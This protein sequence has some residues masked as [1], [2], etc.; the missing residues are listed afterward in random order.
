MAAHKELR[1][2]KKTGGKFVKPKMQFVQHDAWNPKK[3]GGEYDSSKEVTE[4]L[5]GKEVKGVWIQKGTKGVFDYEEF[6]ETALE[7]SEK[8]HDSKDAPFSEAGLARKKKAALEQFEQGSQAR[9]K[10]AVEHVGEELSMEA[11][12]AAVQGSGA[13][14]SSSAP[15]LATGPVESVQLSESSCSSGGSSSSEEG[16]AENIFGPKTKASQQA[17]GAAA[18]K[19]KQNLPSTVAKSSA[20]PS[21]PKQHDGAAATK[22]DRRSGAERHVKGPQRQ[23]TQDSGSSTFLADGRA[24]RALRNLLEKKTEL[25]SK[26]DAVKVDDA[27]PEPDAHSQAAFKQSC[28]DRV[29]TLKTLGRQA[30]DYVKRMDKSANKEFFEEGILALQEVETTALALQNLLSSVSTPGSVP[31]VIV[32]AYEDVTAQQVSLGTVRAST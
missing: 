16:A 15:A 12:V 24:Q 17:Q 3:H 1:L 14:A 28:A 4:E 25:K 32:K 31:D 7:E 19:P 8:L 11:L 21:A 26:L 13:S 6:Q 10:H 2:Q 18:S 29:A 27:N 23:D 30:R 22:P 20:K 5:F 9:E